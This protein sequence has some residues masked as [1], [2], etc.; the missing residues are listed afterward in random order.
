LGEDTAT[1]AV[2]LNQDYADLTIIGIGSE[3]KITHSGINKGNLFIVGPNSGTS[4]DIVLTIGNNITINGF[5]SN[6]KAM[7]FVQN[8]ATFNM[9]GSSKITG[10]TSDGSGYVSDT[11]NAGYGAAAVHIDNAKFNMTGGTITGNENGSSTYAVRSAGAVYAELNSTVSISGGSITSNTNN[12]GKGTLDIFINVSSKIELSGSPTIGEIGLQLGSSGNSKI[13]V[14]SDF[15][16]TAKINLHNV[17]S[18]GNASW[19]GKVI[20]DGTGVASTYT[21]FSLGNFLAATN[22]PITNTLTLD[23]TGM[24]RNKT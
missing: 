16:T 20:L 15:T 3:R 7:V 18:G 13:F 5:N 1:P 12:S 8:G 22:V 21:K 6:T 9:T 4:H 10:N 23:G 2:T 17:G 11:N 14:K 19:A 24:L